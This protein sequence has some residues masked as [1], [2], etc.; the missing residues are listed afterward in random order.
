MGQERGVLRSLRRPVHTVQVRIVEEIAHLAPALV[1]HLRPLRTPID[2][3]LQATQVEPV[4]RFEFEFGGWGV[5]QRPVATDA[6]QHLFAIGADFKAVRIAQLRFLAILE[7]IE[8]DDRPG[9]RARTETLAATA[10]GDGATRHPT[11]VD[12]F[13]DHAG[14][15][16]A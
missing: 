13:T 6:E 15:A 3:R 10:A 12:L 1:E 2:D 7:V 11:I 8:S 4:L 16:V 14:R 9:L 5:D